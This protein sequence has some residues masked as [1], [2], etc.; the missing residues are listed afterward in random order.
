[1]FFV[2]A[3]W[4]KKSGIKEAVAYIKKEFISSMSHKATLFQFYSL[5][6]K[7]VTETEQVNGGRSG[8]DL[9]NLLQKDLIWGF[10]YS[11]ETC[12]SFLK[13]CI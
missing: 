10:Y 13:N 4:E 9:V 8:L 11:R 7:Q 6:P 2:P 5:W 3:P 1:M 12:T